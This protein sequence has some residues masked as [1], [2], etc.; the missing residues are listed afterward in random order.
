MTRRRR[1]W[2]KLV[3]IALGVVV[4]SSPAAFS[5]VPPAQGATTT[6]VGAN[7]SD[8]T[9]FDKAVGPVQIYRVFDGGFHYAT[10]RATTAYQQ[11]PNAPAFDYSIRVLPQRLTNPTDPINAQIRSF[12]ATTPKNLIITNWHEPDETYAKNRQFTTV[13]YRAGLLALARMVRAQNAADGGTRRVSL[14][15]MDITFSGTWSTQV[16]DWWPTN[17]RDGGHVDLIQGDMYEWPHATNTPGVPAGY[18][19][20]IN[21]RKAST[22]LAPL[23]NWA[24]AH[25]TPWAVAELGVLEDIHNPMRK[26]NELSAAVAYAKSHGADHIS[27]FDNAG[28]RANWRLRYS[29]PVGTT[30]PTSNAAV[31]WKSLV[32]GG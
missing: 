22:L 21:W 32:A 5:P 1:L 18:T 2:S 24:V 19:D 11:H 31:M 6:R 20:G 4:M 10:W 26:A 25:D 8:W 12:L 30:S 7:S 3:V 13:Q 16:S 23:Y 27:Y 17:A 15:L 28:P 14:T 29:T 9:W